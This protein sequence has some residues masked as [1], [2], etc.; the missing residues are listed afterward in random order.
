MTQRRSGRADARLDHDAGV[1]PGRAARDQ[2]HG[3]LSAGRG[4][5]TC[6]AL[7]CPYL[8]LHWSRSGPLGVV[9]CRCRAAGAWPDDGRTVAG[10]PTAPRG[11]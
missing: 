3:R 11:L 10:L 2:P 4:V 6:T 5:D 8:R 7:R 1:L 9:Q